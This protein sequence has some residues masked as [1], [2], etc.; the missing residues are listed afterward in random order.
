MRYLPFENFHISITRIMH[1]SLD[2]YSASVE[3][4]APVKWSKASSR[5]DWLKANVVTLIV[6]FSPTLSIFSPRGKITFFSTSFV[7]SRTCLRGER[8]GQ[9]RQKLWSHSGRRSFAADWKSPLICWIASAAAGDNST[10]RIYY[11]SRSSFE[12][13]RRIHAFLFGFFQSQCFHD[14][15]ALLSRDLYAGTLLHGD[16]L[17]NRRGPSFF[18]FWT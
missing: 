10:L 1:L 5:S 16:A 18:F 6:A 9:S 3:K 15:F 11:C 4:C 2:W 12:L 17:G 14:C 8:E 13:R 7:C